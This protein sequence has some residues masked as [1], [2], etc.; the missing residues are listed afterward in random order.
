[1]TVK[2]ITPKINNQNQ[3]KHEDDTLTQDKTQNA[4]R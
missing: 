2:N 1:M 4:K 3:N